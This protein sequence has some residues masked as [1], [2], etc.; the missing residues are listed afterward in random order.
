M[1]LVLKNI[2]SLRLELLEQSYFKVTLTQKQITILSYSIKINNQKEST[3]FIVH[4]CLSNFRC[5]LCMGSPVITQIWHSKM[6][7]EKGN[8]QRCLW[9][10]IINT[11]YTNVSASLVI[12][13]EVEGCSKNMLL[14]SIA[15][16]NKK[17]WILLGQSKIGWGVT[18]FQAFVTRC[19]EAITLEMI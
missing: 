7:T 1:L 17:D 4:T 6:W 10:R 19:R 13:L 16:S 12:S 9:M 8:D 3:S 15:L 14:L 2:S 11:R 5:F 18:A